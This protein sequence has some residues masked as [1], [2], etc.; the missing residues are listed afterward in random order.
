M[1]GIQDSP[2]VAS[3]VSGTPR[4]ILRFEGALVLTCAMTA[5]A[6]HGGLWSLFALLF[7]IPDLSMLGYLAGSRV[8]AVS[9]NVAHS[10]VLPLVAGLIGAVCLQSILLD[11][12]LIWIAHIGFDRMLGYGLKYGSAFGHTHL[13]HVGRARR[14]SADRTGL[15]TLA[16][17]PA[18]EA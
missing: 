1:I 2:N 6:W 15:P 18:H 16:I 17:S 12:A 4:E 14:V 9:Y 3:A 13:G 5:F 8:G 7:L 10:Y 11:G